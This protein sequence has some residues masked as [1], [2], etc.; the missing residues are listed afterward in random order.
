MNFTSVKNCFWLTVYSAVS[1]DF[2][3]LMTDTGRGEH[4]SDG[5]RG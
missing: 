1:I 3:Q 5:A 4:R 2:W